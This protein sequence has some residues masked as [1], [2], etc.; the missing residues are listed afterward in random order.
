MPTV[1]D[2]L[3]EQNPWWRDE[4]RLEYRERELYEELQPF[5]S[6][7]WIIALTG[8]RRVG[9]TTLMLKMIQD[10][11]S[12]GLEPRR[13][14]YFSF[15]E[16]RQVE[17]R[18]ILREYMAIMNT[19]LSQ[20]EH[21]ILFDEIQK[22]EGWADQLKALYD[23]YQKRTKI[24]IS[25]SESLF[26][27]RGIRESL[28]GRMLTFQLHPLSFREYLQFVGASFEPVELHER[29]LRRHFEAFMRTEGFP[30]LVGVREEAVIRKHLHESVLERVVFRD[31]TALLGIRDVEALGALVTILTEEPGQVV[32]LRD[33]AGQLGVSR[34]TLSLYLTYLEQAFLLRKLYNFSKVRRKSERRL[35]RY[36]PTVLSPDLLFREDG[37]SR[38]RALEWIVVNQL[39]AEYFWRDPY[40]H[41]VDAVLTNGQ[42][43]PVEV[44][45]GRVDL[46]G[47]RAFMRRFGVSRGY[48]VTQDREGVHRLSEGE[49]HVVPAYK[50]LLGVEEILG[51]S[52]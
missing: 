13:V 21:L 46:S 9:K 37:L 38:S 39:R 18:E 17:L 33:L 15:D 44:K 27:R 50:F 49:V 6:R 35:K 10:R 48:V 28:A 19:D 40:K 45:S 42:P 16:F 43:I 25:G 26:I 22:L 7:P 4:F 23:R 1:R 51:L 14:L 29:D 31:L 52:K 32:V 24:I 20:G 3:V 2:A 41:E 11:I 8:L 30:E 36:Y 12:R 34:Q 47:L 5:L